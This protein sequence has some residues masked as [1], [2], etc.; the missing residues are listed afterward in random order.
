LTPNWNEV[1]HIKNVPASAELKV[2]V[3][4]KDE[5]TFR[6]DYIGKF[7]TAINSSGTRE[8]PITS[9]M[10]K[11]HGTFVLNVRSEMTCLRDLFSNGDVLIRLSQTHVSTQHYPFT[12]LRVLVGT[13]AIGPLP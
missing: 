8:L 11:S 4:D 10:G 5:G 13:R 9:M 6:D 1:W 2:K 3:W 7:S 12:H